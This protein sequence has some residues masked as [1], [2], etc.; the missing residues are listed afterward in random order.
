MSAA[1]EAPV[2]PDAA[3]AAAWRAAVARIVAKDSAGALPAFSTDDGIPLAPLYPKAEGEAAQAQRAEI[4][5]RIVQRVDH[6]DPFEAKALAQ[7]DLEGGAQ[8]LTLAFDDAPGARGFGLRARDAEDLNQALGGIYLDMI[9][10]R[11]EPAPSDAQAALR[12]AQ[13]VERRG[14]DASLIDADFG[15]DPVGDF[16]LRGGAPRNWKDEE[17]AVAHACRALRERGFRGPVMRVDGRRHEEAG[18]SEAEELAAALATGLA[19]A[20]ALESCGLL[21]DASKGLSFTLAAGVEILPT[22][23]KL[24]AL[25][26]LWAL[27]EES[28][29]LT[30]APLR[31]HAETSWRMMAAR[32]VYGNILRGALG[33]AGAMIGG[34]DTVTVLPMTA[35]LGLP[36]AFARRLARNTGIVLAEESFL[37]SVADPAAGSGAIESL[38]EALCERAWDLF[39]RIETA[40]GFP[41]AVASGFWQDVLAASRARRRREVA[42]RSRPIVGVSIFSNLAEA[43][44]A[45]LASRPAPFAPSGEPGALPCARDAEPFERLRDRSDAFLGRHGARPRVVLALLAGEGGGAPSPAA[46]RARD[47]A[48]SVFEAG[49]FLTQDDGEAAEASVFAVCL[50]LGDAGSS[51]EA[52]PAAE[53]AVR[54]LHAGGARVVACGWPGEAEAELRRAGVD[55]FLFK[56]SDAVS[57]L[58]RV[59]TRK[60]GP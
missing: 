32:D 56:G 58:Q 60:P 34:A 15:F 43:A 31:L 25:R 44:P 20:R 30:P 5:C 42:S 48:R 4:G 1:D 54:R 21:D 23:A 24:R 22:I 29:G 8:G 17:S 19:Y 7:A 57:F 3:G 12:F 28:C 51:R 41:K 26:R 40:G 49:G 36:D 33:C 11:L 47:F 55:D 6:F 9:Q 37:A 13:V 53:K 18:A 14:Y 27:V 35:T 50:C 59:W 38:T 52:D 10:T 16:A 2:F 45:T 46:R 39:Q